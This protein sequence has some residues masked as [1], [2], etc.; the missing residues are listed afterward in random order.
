M[1][2]IKTTILLAVILLLSAGTASANPG[3]SVSVTP[4]A[5]ITVAPGE[6]ASYALSVFL[7]PDGLGSRPAH[8]SITN[9]VA[10]W[11]YTFSDNDFVI[12]EGQ[13]IPVTLEVGVAA[14]TTQGTY[15]SDGDASTTVCLDGFCIAGWDATT[16]VVYTTAIPEFPTVALPIVSIIGLMLLFQKRKHN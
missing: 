6:T 12:S 8:L 3:I 11:T 10:G 7:D 14:D 13:T 16:F 15:A 1:E 4:P 2:K 5:G 9:P